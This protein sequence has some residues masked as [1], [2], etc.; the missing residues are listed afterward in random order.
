M[1]STRL[2]KK[3]I[4]HLSAVRFLSLGLQRVALF[5]GMCI[6]RQ[7]PWRWCCWW[8]GTGKFC[9]VRCTC[10]ERLNFHRSDQGGGHGALSNTM[11]MGVDRIVSTVRCYCLCE[12]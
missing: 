11:G 10:V 6:I 1:I 4:L 9:N 12:G 8:M 5:T 3:T 7:R 2:P